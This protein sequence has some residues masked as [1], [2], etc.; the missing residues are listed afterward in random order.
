[1]TNNTILHAERQ[2]YLALFELA[3]K[4]PIATEWLAHLPKW[5]SAIKNKERYANAPYFESAVHKLPSLPVNGIE[6]TATNITA[7]IDFAIDELKKSEALL[8]TLMPW[9]K[10][11]FYFGNDERHIHIDTEWRSDLKWERIAPF[12]DLQDKVVLDVGGGSGYHGFRMAGAGAKQVVVIDPSCLFYFQF[13]AIKHFVQASNV[14]FVPVG[15]EALPMGALFHVVFCMGVLYH[16]KSPFECLEQL[17]AQLKSGG[18]LVLETLVVDGDEST[19]LV[20]ENRYA[21][22]NNVYCLPSVSALTLWLRKVGFVD[23]RCVDVSVTTEQEQRATEWMTYQSLADFL[24]P[25]DDSKTCEGYPRPKRA[26]M[27]A[28]VA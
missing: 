21:K 14:H 13:M 28:R 25:N 17:K 18:T 15:L 2:L 3:I 16:R 23:I 20:P 1:M 9:R 11:G 6:L 5:L 8:K 4:H 27:I 24:H 12:V 7:H 10:G 26:V 22:M 19:V